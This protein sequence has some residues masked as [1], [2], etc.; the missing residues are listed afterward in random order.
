MD[1]AR[2]LINF[3]I[4]TE[5]VFQAKAFGL[6]KTIEEIVSE[7]GFKSE[8]DY[9][10]VALSEPMDKA[11]FLH[12]LQIHLVPA[13]FEQTSTHPRSWTQEWD[14]IKGFINSTFKLALDADEPWIIKTLDKKLL[15][16]PREAVNWLLANRM[17]EALV[18]PGLRAF[19]EPNRPPEAAG[20]VARIR[21]P[22]RHSTQLATRGPGRPSVVTERV[23]SAMRACP[24]D[25]LMDMKQKVMAARFGASRDIC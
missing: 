6:Q 14:R 21:A 4:A 12:L 10:E 7:H 8:A 5:A 16:R 20:L 22:L 25:E 11:S 23:I 1:Y 9:W 15:V 24:H 17:R 13:P 19:L 2:T 3:K 18:P